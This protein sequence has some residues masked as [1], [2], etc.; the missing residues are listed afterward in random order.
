LEA[1]ASP[2]GDHEVPDRDLVLSLTPEKADV[3]ADRFRRV[4]KVLGPGKNKA[5]FNAVLS[6]TTDNVSEAQ[7]VVEK[8][9]ERTTKRWKLDEVVTHIGKPSEIYFLLRLKKT[10]PR[11]EVITAIH[12]HAG[13]VLLTADIEV[14]EPVDGKNGAKGG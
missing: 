11:D 13:G 4:R 10:M 8:V 14:G 12:D 1:L 6:L 7:T 5:R 9:L 2:T 3:L